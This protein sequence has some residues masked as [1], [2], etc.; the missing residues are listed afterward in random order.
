MKAEGGIKKVST[1]KKRPR[2]KYSWDGFEAERE[3]VRATAR[4]IAAADAAVGETNGDMA[5]ITGAVQAFRERP[6]APEAFSEYGQALRDM[7]DHYRN[8]VAR[9]L[10]WDLVHQ[11]MSSILSPNPSHEAMCERNVAR[12]KTKDCLEME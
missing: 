2:Y 5:V 1:N 10:S 12:A 7:G 11:E 6:G 8:L 4:R 9:G 3:K